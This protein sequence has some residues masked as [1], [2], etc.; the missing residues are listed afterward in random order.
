LKF[1]SA[2]NFPFIYLARQKERELGFSVAGVY[3][4]K[5][6]AEQTGPGISECGNGKDGT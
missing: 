1:S 3:N 4:D 2:I 6:L 5:K